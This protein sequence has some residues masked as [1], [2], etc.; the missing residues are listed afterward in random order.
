[1]SSKL[2][3]LFAVLLLSACSGSDNSLDAMQKNEDASFAGGARATNSVFP[4]NEE[5]LTLRPPPNPDR[6]AYFGDLHVHTAYS[7]DAYVF[8]TVSTPDDAYRYA[9][10]QT[11]QHPSGYEVQLQQPMDFYA[12]TDHA[13][14]MGLVKEAADTNSEFS[15]YELTTP[16]HDI[17]APDN[18]TLYSLLDRGRAFASFLPAVVDG[19]LNGDID[20]PMVEAVT[21]SAWQ[22]TIRAANE[23]YIPGTF[24]TFA[25]FEFTSSSDDQGNLHRNVI[26]RDS[27]RLPAMPFSRFN[28]QNPE[29]LWQWMDQLR[30]QGVE[31]LAIPHN[32]NGSNGQMFKMTDWAGDPITDEYAEQR[33]RNEPLVEITQIKGTSET[34]P[35][36]SKNDEWANFEIT[37]YRVG[38][39][40]YSEPAGSYGRDAYLRGLHIQA[41]GAVNPY[42]FGLIGSSDTHDAA[43]SEDEETFFSKA[44]MLDGTP[45]LRGSI[46][47]SFLTGTVMKFLDPGLVTEVDGKDYMASSSFEYWSASGMAGVWAEENTRDAIYQAF[48]RKETF[49]TS[50]PRIKVRFFA[51]YDFTRPLLQSA[52]LTKIAYQRGVTMGADLPGDGARAPAFI[53]WAAADPAGTALQRV[54]IIK[55]YLESG[56]HQERIYDVA[57]ANNLQVDAATGRCPD[58][59]S[60]VDLSDCS[61]TGSGASELKALWRDPD[62]DFRQEAFYY[63]RVLENPSCRWS[64]WD[65]IRAG[66]EPRS[67][68][69]KTL[70]ERAWSSP[71]WYRPNNA[72]EPSGTPPTRDGDI[73]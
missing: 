51:S 72:I 52:Q 15:R 12:V 39:K 31:S 23:A 49:A 58:N 67:D 18:M 37:P 17:N 56:A 1:M 47:A 73:Q 48:R 2:A 14:L 21:K 24:T 70:Q 36:L 35:L 16:L 19:L 40:L 30:T 5:I 25:A 34:H 20:M 8:G 41:K 69:P 55:G 62:F 7:F 46:P 66:V 50:G 22:D 27:D 60:G 6:N 59:D 9:K 10:G 53:V 26:F 38:T 42:K 65:A 68:L 43:S 71:I 54:Q 61:T 3:S 4:V 28:S 33:L 29:G 11:L 32:S 57:C 44:G 63:V 64:T 13:M 45:E